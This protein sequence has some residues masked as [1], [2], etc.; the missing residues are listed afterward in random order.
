M[1]NPETQKLYLKG[2]PV[3]EVAL[4]FSFP[5]SLHALGCFYH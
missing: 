4:E 1:G 5:L 3:I 2:I